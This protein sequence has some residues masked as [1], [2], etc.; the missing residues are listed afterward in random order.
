MK[1][2][3]TGGGT[4]GHFYPLMAVAEEIYEITDKRKLLEPDLYYIGP[5]PYDPQALL[6]H[7][8]KFKK[9]AAGKERKYYSIRN[10]TDRI[11]TVFGIIQATF[12]LYF[13]YPDV[14]LSKG[15]YAAFPTTVAA[16]LLNIPL[17]IHESDAKPG[18]ANLIAA[19]WARAIA[20]SYPGVSEYFS[21]SIPKEKFALTGN[22]VRRSLFIPVHEGA[23]TYLN[24]NPNLQTLFILGGSSGAQ[25]VNKVVLSALPELLEKYQIIHQVGTK[26]LDEVNGIASVILRDNPNKDRYKTFGFLNKLAMRMTA[27]ISSLVITRAGSN[28]IA[29]IAG[30]GLPSIVIPIPEEISHDQ[31]KNAFV[32]ARTGAAIV[33]NQSNLTENI[34]LAEVNHIMTSA[35]LREGMSEAASKFAKPEAAAKLARMLV[36]ISLEHEG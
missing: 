30:W 31:T 13:L 18:K 10:F 11:K 28:T 34:L 19:K 1:I 6:E 15:G 33:I 29:E 36:D 25:A 9:S 20:V 21:Q 24:L 17:I 35:E 4:G 14:I 3:L 2:V 22:P 5:E 27:G 12:Q 7:N 16:R 32:Y 8:I 23:Y 26:N